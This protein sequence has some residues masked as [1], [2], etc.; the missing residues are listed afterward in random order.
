MCTLEAH[1]LS[2]QFC[3]PFFQLP[4][5]LDSTINVWVKSSVLEDKAEESHNYY[6]PGPASCS[7]RWNCRI[8]WQRWILANI[9]SYPVLRICRLI[10]NMS[11]IV[12]SQSWRDMRELWGSICFY[13]GQELGSNQACQVAHNHLYLLL[14]GIQNPLLASEYPHTC[15]THTRMCKHTRAHTQL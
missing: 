14:Q 6:M 1:S 10:F 9:N 13:R 4:Y 5:Q 7:V 8:I 15:G 11:V 2:W 12:I 3:F